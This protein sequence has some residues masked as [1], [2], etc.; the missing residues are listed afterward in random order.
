MINLSQFFIINEA[1]PVSSTVVGHLKTCCIVAL[2]WMYS[3]KALTD[4]SLIGIVLAIGGII[5]FVF[6]LC[7]AI[8]ILTAN[9]YSAVMHK[10]TRA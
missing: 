1:G 5:S 2:G 6:R 9:R 8:Q 7:P 3:G 4:G 10:Q